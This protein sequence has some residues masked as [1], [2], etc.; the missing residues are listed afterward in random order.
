MFNWS[1]ECQE[2][3]EALKA[4]ITQ[5][6]VLVYPN[7]EVD[8]VLETD[9]CGKGL[10]A[11]LSQRQSD[12]ILHPVAYASRSLS[13]AERNYSVTD[14]ETLAVVWAMQHFQ[15]YLFGH[16]VTVVTDHS[17]VKAVLGAPSLS[18]KHARWWLKVF[19]SGV[20]DVHIVYRPG[21]DND[22][23]DALSRNPVVAQEDDHLEVKAQVAQI[24]SASETDI[25]SLLQEEPEEMAT[26]VEGN[27]Q[28]EQRKDPEL[29]ALLAYL[30]SGE[31]PVCDKEAQKVATQAL[32]LAVVGDLLCF[33]DHKNGSRKRV[34]A[35]AHLRE[36]ILKE[37]HGGVYA[38]H[39]SGVKL[40]STV[41]RNWWW[42]TIYKDVMDFCKNCPDCAVVSGAG[43]KQ[44]PPLHP[45]PVQRPF[46]IFGMD[47]MEL[48]MTERGNRYVIVFQ[49]FLTK[50]P[51]VFPAPD[52][53]AIRIARLV[54][55]E[56]VPMFGVP[57]S[58]LSDRGANLLANVMTDVCSLLG[59][60]KLNTTAYHPQCNGMIERMNR[61]LK[62][63]LRKHAVKF[64]PQ[65]DKFLPGVLWAY[66]NAPHGTTKEKPSFLMF[67]LDLRSP[68][69]A[70]LLPAESL[71]PTDV[72]DYREQLI[73]SLSSAGSLL[74]VTFV[75]SRNEPR[76]G[77]T[78]SLL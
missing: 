52:Q 40:Y 50:W 57:E 9:A 31:L 34:V 14:L 21:K 54:A 20:K 30:E 63:M 25:S 72:D 56:I 44:I 41:C 43:R 35:P 49:D 32:H 38:G 68:T 67:G 60:T 45:I 28:N 36:S 6:P 24:A 61:T 17:A 42:P 65:W 78:R 75:E 13:P 10:G 71:E 12:G 47:I 64:G 51:L 46:Q 22:R 7:F 33:I 70:A 62:A 3:F 15:A 53:K 1:P 59:I 48:P 11:V 18:G 26:G 77:M 74:S 66:R 37:S 23:A 4:A 5:S 16:K 2:A 76:S 27:F 39:F 19:G 73:L 8:F 55:E 58:L 69:E 29:K